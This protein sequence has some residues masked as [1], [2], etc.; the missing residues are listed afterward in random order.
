[1]LL[2][3]R[4][5]K[6]KSL[7][8]KLITM[9]LD[10]TIP[11]PADPQESV[12]N[13]LNVSGSVWPPELTD[14][15]GLAPPLSMIHRKEVLSRTSLPVSVR[16]YLQLDHHCLTPATSP[17]RITVAL[18]K[19]QLAAAALGSTASSQ[20]NVREQSRKVYHEVKSVR[21]TICVSYFIL[22]KPSPYQAMMFLCISLVPME[23]FHMKDC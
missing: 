8:Q 6:V 7:D 2:K 18:S 4:R 19:R 21:H 11:D 14:P 3:L 5:T 12:V 15:L 22:G 10:N 17:Y 23:M 13:I 16:Q 9:I 1:M 20:T